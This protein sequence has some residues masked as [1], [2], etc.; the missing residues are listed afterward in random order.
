MTATL[1]AT[2]AE[3]QL[4]AFIAKFG[5]DDQRLIRAVRS[6]LRR[7]M[8][9]AN[10][11]VWDNYNFFV[12][13]YSPTERPTDSIVSMAARA[14]GVGVCFIQGASLPD[15]KGLLLGSGR[16]TRFIR[17]ETARQLS[18]PDVEALIK[19]A[20]AR[21]RRP[22][23]ATG[24]GMLVIRSIA[25]KQRPRQRAAKR[26]SRA[27]RGSAQRQAE[28]VSGMVMGDGS[29]RNRTALGFTVKSGWASAVLVT[30]SVASP[31]VADSRRIDLSDPA[32]PESR[33]PYHA[34]FGAARAAGPDRSR[35][36]ASVK[37]F[38]RQSVAELIRQH[39]TAGHGVCAAG[40]VAGSL[41]DPAS[42]AND[43]IR[44]HAL[45]GQLFR[46]VVEDAV[47][48]S[49]LPCSIW[50][51]RDLYQA[52]AAILN[53]PEPALRETLVALGRGV[54]GPWRAEQKAAALSAWLV[55]AR[56]K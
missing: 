39:Q 33:Q 20:I 44:I 40:L 46:G 38:G 9:T 24:R 37:R 16:Q 5:T 34:G 1:G 28:P 49:D 51:E 52:A 11:L 26:P 30:G 18:H 56:V 22:L 35:L 54:D 43:H 6:A 19:A 7:R 50:R 53:R 25:S 17:V 47:G 32:V 4:R 10:E 15:P 14:N 8:P 55:L 13:G 3:S 12:I 21:A 29:P 23:P 42:I 2:S 41:V 48:R 36:V 45:E 31:V 27:A